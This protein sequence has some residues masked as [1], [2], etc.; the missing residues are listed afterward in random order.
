VKWLKHITATRRDEKVAAYIDAAKNPI[1]AY[2]FWWMVL[3][4][5]A[6]QMDPGDQKCSVTYSLPHWSRLLYSHHHKVVTLLSNL[7]GNSLVTLQ[8]ASSNSV[9]MITVTVPN[10]LK[11]RDEY[12][13]KSGQPKDETPEDVGSKKET[14]KEK[15]TKKRKKP[16]SGPPDYSPG[17]VRFWEVWPSSQRK[18]A[19]SPCFKNWKENQLEQITDSVIAHVEAWKHTEKWRTGFEPAPLTY[20]NQQ[21]WQDGPPPPDKPNA[22]P[23]GNPVDKVQRLRSGEY[24]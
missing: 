5:I 19:K 2:G 4:I 9:K 20:L 18:T 24:T 10:L 6:E 16:P 8:Y 15:E 22:K 3:E 12:S 11:Y 17:F 1:E 21:H 7:E 13:R 23:N 14:K